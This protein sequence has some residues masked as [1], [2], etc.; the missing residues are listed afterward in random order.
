M[1]LAEES[2]ANVDTLVL[3]IC[4]SLNFT[5]TPYEVVVIAVDPPPQTMLSRTKRRKRGYSQ[6]D[7]QGAKRQWVNIS[8]NWDKCP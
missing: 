6:D 3:G 8:I 7:V 5:A 1:I 2:R 4:G